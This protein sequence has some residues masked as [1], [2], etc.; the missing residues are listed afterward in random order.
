MTLNLK[1]VG[2]LAVLG[3]VVYLIVLLDDVNYG[4]DLVRSIIEDEIRNSHL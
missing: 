3:I 4:M 2:G 1:I